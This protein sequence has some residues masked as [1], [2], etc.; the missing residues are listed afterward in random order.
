M[1]GAAEPPLQKRE[2]RASKKPSWKAQSSACAR[3]DDGSRGCAKNCAEIVWTHGAGSEGM[4][5]IVVPMISGM[6]SSTM[7]T[8]L[9]VPRDAP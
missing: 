6:V 7:L 5:R 8:L 3:N 1:R 2:T 9:V 4:Q